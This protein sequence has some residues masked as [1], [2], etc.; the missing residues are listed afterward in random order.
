MGE[1]PSAGIPLCLINRASVVEAKISGFESF[2]PASSIAC[3]KIDHQGL[4]MLVG[5]TRGRPLQSVIGPFSIICQRKKKLAK[6][7]VYLE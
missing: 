1:K 7:T 2:P 4:E 5:V 3:L 6:S